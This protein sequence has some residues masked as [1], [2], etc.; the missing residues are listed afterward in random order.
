MRTSAECYT[1]YVQDCMSVYTTQFCCFNKTTGNDSQA[2]TFF[3]S[4]SGPKNAP[5]NL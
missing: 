3:K 1:E 4:A 2:S 5:A